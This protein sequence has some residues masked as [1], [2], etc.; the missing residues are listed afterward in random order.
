MEDSVFKDFAGGKCTL[1]PWSHREVGVDKVNGV[2]EFPKVGIRIF[3]ERGCG[4]VSW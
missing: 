3:A 4:G 2:W 1:T